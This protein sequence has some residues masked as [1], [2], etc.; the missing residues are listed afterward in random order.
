MRSSGSRLVQAVRE[1]INVAKKSGVRLQIS[2]HKACGRENW[3][4]I[5]PTLKMID[6]A[7]SGGIDVACDRYPYLATSQGLDSEIPTWA[8]EGGS[9]KLVERIENG[10]LRAKIRKE[11]E[12]RRR[13]WD[14]VVISSVGL[15]K[16]KKFE[17]KSVL[18][19]A[20]AQKKDPR[21]FVLDLIAEENNAVMSINFLMSE[22]NLFTVLRHPVTAIGSDGCAYSAR[23]VLKRG[24]P[25]PRSYGTFPR[26]LGRYCREKKILPLED[27]I[28]RMTSLPAQRLGIKDRG[29]IKEGVHA[30]IVIFDPERVIDKA[31]Y[32]R[33]H[34]YPSGIE[35]VMVNG[36][37]VV[38]GKRHTGALAGKVLRHSMTA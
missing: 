5:K 20:D 12:H 28:R 34:Q 9:E 17:G 26:V 18:K 31:S 37:I 21:D 29:L 7:R 15:R 24:K 36:K 16:N 4:K 35:Y 2:H 30:D 8:R 22:E 33:P 25:H 38:A 27:A 1:V 10:R 14:N 11:M 23:G 32:L 19:V 6:D 13:E 3:S